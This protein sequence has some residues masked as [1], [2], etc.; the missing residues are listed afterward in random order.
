MPQR[1]HS[2]SKKAL[3][4][5]D[6]GTFITFNDNHGTHYNEQIVK[7]SCP[8]GDCEWHW[9]GKAS[10]R[11]YTLERHMLHH[12]YE[13]EMQALKT[14]LEEGTAFDIR[15]LGAAMKEFPELVFTDEEIDMPME[16]WHY[17]GNVPSLLEVRQEGQ[18]ILV[19][20]KQ[21]TDDSFTIDEDF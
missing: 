10:E 5:D 20:R 4:E 15:M 6:V 7:V 18:N 17:P 8:R 16:S 14:A 2:A 1:V 3:T 13:E 19:A 9:I 11:Q 21:Q 12:S